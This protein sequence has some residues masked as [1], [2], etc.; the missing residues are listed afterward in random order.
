MK[1]K[2]KSSLDSLSIDYLKSIFEYNPI[3]GHLIW[4]NR[5]TDSSTSNRAAKTWNKRFASKIAG[6]LNNEG[7]IRVGI[8]GIAY[9]AHRIAY[10]MHFMVAP[11]CIDH[12]DGD[13][14]NNKIA[15]LRSVTNPENHK[16]LKMRVDNKSGVLGV[17]WNKGKRKWVA[18]IKVDG[19]AVHIGYFNSIEDAAE[20]RAKASAKHGFHA[21]HGER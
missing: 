13:R 11:N 17:R 20:A 2:P 5:I 1:Q 19:K 6:H 14:S 7:Y 10:F 21:N 4:K 9:R 8:N 12:I 16:N 15:N 3:T 18:Q